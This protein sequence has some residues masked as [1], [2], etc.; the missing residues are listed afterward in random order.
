MVAMLLTQFCC[1]LLARARERSELGSTYSAR[2]KVLGS[3]DAGNGSNGEGLHLDG[4][5]EE[6]EVDVD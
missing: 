3:S 1:S 6:G 5:F 2:S 4:R